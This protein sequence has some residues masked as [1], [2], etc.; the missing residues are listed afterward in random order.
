[1][2]DEM[3]VSRAALSDLMAEVP[4]SIVNQL[5]SRVDPRTGGSSSVVL[6][7]AASPAILGTRRAAC[8]VSAAGRVRA[9]RRWP[10]RLV[11]ALGARVASRPSDAVPGRLLP[12]PRRTRARAWRARFIRSSRRAGVP[13]THDVG[14]AACDVIDDAEVR[15]AQFPPAAIRQGGRTT[16]CPG[17]TQPLVGPGCG[18]GDRVRRLVRWCT[19]PIGWSA[20][21]RHR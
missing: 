3:P 1:M 17:G 6:S 10:T 15:R 16:A 5:P 4:A 18:S 12:D 19:A 13:G 11:T 8:S 9:R 14:L 20:S 7:H 2:L 21:E